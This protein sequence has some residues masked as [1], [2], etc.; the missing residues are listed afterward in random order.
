MSLMDG[1]DAEYWDWFIDPVDVILSR[2]YVRDLHGARSDIKEFVDYMDSSWALWGIMFG[3]FAVV[4]ASSL[5]EQA[6]EDMKVFA[7]TLPEEPNGIDGELFDCL[8]SMEW[9]TGDPNRQTELEPFPIDNKYVYFTAI[10]CLLAGLFS[11]L[12][13]PENTTPSL[14]MI[15]VLQTV[16]ANT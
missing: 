8:V 2:L 3:T 13:L 16:S 4:T 12:D 5:D 1:R 6:R 14:V 9:I 10:F 7:M 15:S 11:V